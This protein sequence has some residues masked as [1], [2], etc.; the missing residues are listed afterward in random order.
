MTTNPET[1]AK[2][3]L[4]PVAD[5]HPDLDPDALWDLLVK[6]TQGIMELEKTGMVWVSPFLFI[7]R[8]NEMQALVRERRL[9]RGLP[10]CGGHEKCGR[11]PDVIPLAGLQETA[12]LCPAHAFAWITERVSQLQRIAKTGMGDPF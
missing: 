12:N 9:K 2:N 8:G 4:R 10:V 5:A 3:E 1:S 11:K 6:T 7:S